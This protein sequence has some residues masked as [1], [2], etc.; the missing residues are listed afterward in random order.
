MT[1]VSRGGVVVALMA[2]FLE[3]T[4][5]TGTIGPHGISI[6]RQVFHPDW[7]EVQD[8]AAR[9]T[10]VAARFL[11]PPDYAGFRVYARRGT[12]VERRTGGDALG[13]GPDPA[14][15]RGS[16]RGGPSRATPVSSPGWRPRMGR[17]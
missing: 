12:V 9:S 7:R 13:T 2:A 8:W 6:A 11:T 1:A 16:M 10:P 14:G 3:L 5:Y 15:S 4:F 17:G